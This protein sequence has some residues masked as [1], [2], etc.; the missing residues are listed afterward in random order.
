MGKPK[1]A[2]TGGRYL[3]IDFKPRPWHR[4]RSFETHE[5]YE[6]IRIA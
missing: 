5:I 6:R 2:K 3:A 1:E 4:L